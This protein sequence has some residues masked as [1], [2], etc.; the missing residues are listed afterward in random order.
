MSLYLLFKVSRLTTVRTLV[1]IIRISSTDDSV[2]Y[3]SLISDC[4][5]AMGGYPTLHDT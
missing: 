1:P 4:T 3:S 2:R 5:Y